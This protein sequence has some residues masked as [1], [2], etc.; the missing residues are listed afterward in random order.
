MECVAVSIIILSIAIIIATDT[1]CDA[2][3]TAFKTHNKKVK[4]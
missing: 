2:I 1:L 3:R 4:K